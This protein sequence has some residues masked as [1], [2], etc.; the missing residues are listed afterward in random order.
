MK[1]VV[2]LL[3]L[4]SFVACTSALT[5]SKQYEDVREIFLR[6]INL[7]N[8]FKFDE[9]EAK[10]A[11]DLQYLFKSLENGEVWADEGM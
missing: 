9:N 11:K 5:N 4:I 10:C 8:E 6:G 1:V 2:N 7:L 3:I